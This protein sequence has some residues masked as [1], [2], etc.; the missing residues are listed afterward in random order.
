MDDYTIDLAAVLTSLM[1]E[2]EQ[3][4][5]EAEGVARQANEHLAELKGQRLGIMK[6]FERS[7]APIEHHFPAEGQDVPR[8]G[9][10]IPLGNGQEAAS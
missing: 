6:V 3:Q 10:A 1:A 5:L 4:I 9:P 2:V 8:L 7:R